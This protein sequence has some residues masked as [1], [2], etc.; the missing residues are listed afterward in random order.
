M[1]FD[2]PWALLVLPLLAVYFWALTRR[3]YA[4]LAPASLR[5]ALGAR[6]L[7][8][9]LLTLALAG[10][11]LVKRSDKLTTLFVLDVSRSIRP[12]QRAQ[13]L[14][15][16]RKALAS[17]GRDDPAGVIV[18]GRTSYLEDAPVDTLQEL[19]DIRASV[20]G[21]ATDLAGALRL[22]G[23]AFP[24]DTGRKIVVLSDGNENLGDAEA[25]MEGLRA[26][27]VRI[28]VAP[29]ALGQG[30]GGPAS[31]EAMVDDVSL[32]SHVRVAAP[33]RLR[34]VVSSTV[35]QHATLS[36]LRDGQ[37]IV[38]QPVTLKAG[39][40]A[41][42][43]PEKISQT[44]FH[45]Y[46][47]QLEPTADG[48]PENNHAFGFVSVQGRPRV[49]YVADPDAPGAQS[50]KRAMA[51]QDIDVQTQSPGA[52]PSSVAELASYDSVVL[53]D[54]PS[55]ELGPTQMA[56]LE[57]AV[58]DFGVGF[59]MIGG[60]NSFGAG[61]YNG[62]PIETAL[63]VKMDV[64]KDRRL[65]SAAI[66]IVLDASGSMSATEGGVEKVQLGARAAVQLMGALQPDDQVAVTAV[67]ET[68][69]VIV[70]LQSASKAA[71]ARTAIESVHAGGG[72]IFCNQGLTDAYAILL[73]SKAPIK[74]V[75]L[76]ADTSDSEQQNDCVAL[77]AE[78]LGKNHIT[79]TVCGIGQPSDQHVAFQRAVARAG[80]G[81]LFIVNQAGDLPRLFQRDVQT[82]QQ[83]WFVEKPILPRYSASDTVIAGI[84]FAAEPP[85]LGYN[86]STPK[87]GATV[88]LSSPDHGDPI[89]AY[90]RYGL[91]RTFA[92]TSDDRPHWAI[93]WLP[94]AGYSQFWAQA[95]R[96]S[97][98]S[99][100]GA[101]FQTTVENRDGKGHLVVDAFSQSGGFLNKAALTARVVAPDASAKPLTLSQTAP[102]R[103]EGDFDADQTG[104]YMINVRQAP[105][106]PS[107][108]LGAGGP[109]AP[110]QTVGF[111]VP[112]SPEYRTI[113]PNLPLL[114]RL[115]EG[116]GGR[117]Q[118]DPTRVFRDAPSW[119]VGVL[120]LAPALLL[121]TALLF[122]ADIAVRRLAVRASQVRETAARGAEAAR[123][124]VSAVQ[125]ALAP[126]PATVTAPQMDRLLERKVAA[127]TPA[128]AE[129]DPGQAQRLL[130]RRAVRTG[131][132]PDDPFPQVASLRTKPK[133]AEAAEGEDD[134][135]SRLQDAQRR[136]RQR[137]D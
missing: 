46:D 39:K 91:G 75:I 64:R 76:C 65:P 37:P 57:E 14:D 97:L 55:E 15:Y 84:P 85:L 81:Q 50:L 36:V 113:G 98:R 129:D 135:T 32:P 62:T 45:R 132:D 41:F 16:V 100:T 7:V 59:G 104:A 18:F 11:H 71:S 23:A 2:R 47:A 130:A 9:A 131:A 40:N 77:A 24:P 48:T 10:A 96:W 69:D 27:G 136:A 34:V 112:Y 42:S 43:F 35:P 115:T 12:D 38:R 128:T 68:T 33:F 78:M 94:W 99:N 108:S 90:W 119:V 80:G 6:V 70:P 126:P 122:L 66:V 30:A 103:Y 44:G 73:A 54:V 49:L 31:P 92:F 111:V 137:D 28:D 121:L 125:T 53:S 8:A 105:K 117:I 95:L 127:R 17:K 5:L 114:T 107:P 4:G 61:R 86:L 120:D 67:T 124:G 63:P 109:S 1:S 51:A 60:P 106:E 134:Y 21:D 116:T 22:A 89:F 19:G 74:H 133:P 118:P 82:I 79:T 56:A 3:S 93:Q 101:D 83:N 58:K 88:A 87:P 26:Q 110:S 20:A 29:T 25:E 52:V 13:A 72:G 123:A 102:G